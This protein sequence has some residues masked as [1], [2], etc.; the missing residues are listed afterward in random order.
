AATADG[1][2]LVATAARATGTLWRM[3]IG[4]DHAGAATATPLSA[5][6]SRGLS[7]RL[8]AGRLV[9]RAP[10]AGSAD[11]LWQLVDG[12]ETELWN[13]AEGRVTAGAALAPDGT[14]VVFPVR[15]STGTQLYVMD[16]DGSAP[17]VLVDKV[18]V[19][20]GPAW[21]PAGR[22]S[23]FAAMRC[24]SPRLCRRSAQ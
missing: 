4:D 2:R 17:R 11:S 21:S 23:A 6:D 19:R 24:G 13:G 7:P 8:G 3:P 16:V 9:Y 20:G 1:R 14:R 18:Q 10:K 15:R 12:A 22:W 5:H